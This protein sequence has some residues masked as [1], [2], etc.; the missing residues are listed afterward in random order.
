MTR[1]SSIE[2]VPDSSAAEIIPIEEKL[3]MPQN[4]RVSALP[5]LLLF[6]LAACGGS[7]G[8]DSTGQMTLSITDAPVE[9]A[10]SV[11]VQFSGVAFKRAGASA[12]SV[13][14]FTPSPRQLNLLEYQEGR[15][16]LLL[17]RVILPA[18]DY[19]WIRL[20]VDNQAGVRDSYLTL[21]T[22][23]ECELR[24][25]SGAESGLKLNRGFT[26][27]AD[28]SAA[29]T[30]DFDLRKS[31][32]A[33]PGQQ[34]A[35]SECTQGYLL[36]PTLRVVDDANVGAIAG[37]VDSTLITP[38]CLAKVYIFSGANVVV[39]D[40]EDVTVTNDQDA[41][42]VAGVGMDE[43]DTEYRYHAAFLPPGPYTVAFTCSNDSATTDDALT[44]LPALNTTVTANLISTVDFVPP[45]P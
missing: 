28:G 33:P 36:R 11:V 5:S 13:Q 9:D 6:G 38:E 39:D 27:P 32:H 41:L 18:G 8:G 7:G 1:P 3:A 31:I 30:I 20:I 44:F 23:E 22:G 43:G 12:E 14:N 45:T 40:L 26:L 34:S 17:D 15:A 42:L 4:S 35:T 19:E 21:Q 37:A 10:S 25:P 24:V 2:R 16:A 29:L